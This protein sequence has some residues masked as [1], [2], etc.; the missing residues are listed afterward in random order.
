MFGIDSVSGIVATV[1]VAWVLIIVIGTVVVVPPLGMITVITDGILVLGVCM[2]FFFDSLVPIAG[3][4]SEGSVASQ[5]SI[6]GY[7]GG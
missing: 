7:W 2:L 5:G 3:L 6:N 4:H 1:S